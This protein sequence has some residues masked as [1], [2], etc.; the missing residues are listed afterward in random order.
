MKRLSLFKLLDLLA[1]VVII[2]I[3]IFSPTTQVQSQPKVKSATTSTLF[4]PQP[5]DNFEPAP[6]VSAQAIYIID[7]DTGTTIYEKNGDLFTYPASTT[8][9]MTALVALK[10]YFLDQVL[11]VRSAA[12]A[13]GQT[14]DLS[15]GD[16]LTVENLLYGLLVDSGNDAAVTLAENY[17]GGYTQFILKMNEEAKRLGL[18]STHF[19]NVAGF[20]NP[21]HFTSAR[22]LTSIANEAI[23]NA[24]IR[25]IVSTKAI[26][27]SDITGKRKFHLESTNKL[28]GFNGV[29]GLKTGWT[30]ESGECLITLVTREG[31]SILVTLLNSTDRFGESARLINWVYDNYTWNQI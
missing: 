28:L 31:R 17:P 20:E 8:K 21:D 5:I 22:D 1:V 7:P 4:L 24:V 12:G 10:T 18:T 23:K 16:Q 13:S 9:L 30:P 11:T 14:I 6:I 26:T 2:L 25:K 27:I 19:A 29:K 3:F 15:K